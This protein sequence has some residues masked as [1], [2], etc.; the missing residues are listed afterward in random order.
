MYHP[1]SASAK[2]NPSFLGVPGRPQSPRVS[3][4]R[5]RPPVFDPNVNVYRRSAT[6]LTDRPQARGEAT[7]GARRTYRSIGHRRHPVRR[8]VACSSSDTTA[9]SEATDR[10]EVIIKPAPSL[11][12][13]PP[14]GRSLAPSPRFARSVAP[15]V[16]SRLPPVAPPSP[17][18]ASVSRSLST[19]T[20]SFDG[21]LT[22]EVTPLKRA[23]D[24]AGLKSKAVKSSVFSKFRKKVFLGESG[25]TRQAAIRPFD[26]IVRD[27]ERVG[28]KPVSSNW[29]SSN[30]LYADDL[31]YIA[32]VLEGSDV[33]TED[34]LDILLCQLEEMNNGLCA[35]GR[36]TRLLQ[37][38]WSSGVEQEKVVAL[39]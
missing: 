30:S 11:R 16:G 32:C 35:Q 5:N 33:V 17:P 14:Y 28:R 38:I 4:T 26:T 31:L 36:T 12:S 15:S 8:C 24:N 2:L 27:F 23:I 19:N 7:V 34:Y 39:V 18:V 21:R 13:R 6:S 3:A 22:G 9:G 10:S 37:S 20:H 29:D 25:R 1:K